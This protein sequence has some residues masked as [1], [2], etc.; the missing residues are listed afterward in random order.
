MLETGPTTLPLETTGDDSGTETD[1]LE[2]ET[3]VLRETLEMET[4]GSQL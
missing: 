4:G 2:L 3:P 1:S